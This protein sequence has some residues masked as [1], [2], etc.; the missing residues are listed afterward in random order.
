MSQSVT[1]VSK[2]GR[3]PD[4]ASH[5]PSWVRAVEFSSAVVGLASERGDFHFGLLDEL[6]QTI[7]LARFD[8][9]LDAGAVGIVGCARGLLC[10][11]LGECECT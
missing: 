3:M 1:L 2:I 4:S 6:Q 9:G 8:A 5:E 11:R 10:K 7:D